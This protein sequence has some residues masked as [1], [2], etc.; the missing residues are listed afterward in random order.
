MSEEPETMPAL[1][2]A[3]TDRPPPIIPA[4]GAERAIADAIQQV[5]MATANLAAVANAVA[6]ALD[7]TTE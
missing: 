6:R 3:D 5:T 1:A 7:A 2:T 4:G